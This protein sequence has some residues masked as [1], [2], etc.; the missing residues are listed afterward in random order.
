L[1][2]DATGKPIEDCQ[3]LLG[4]IGS[5]PLLLGQAAAYIKQT[6]MEVAEY[7][8]NFEQN[9]SLEA[10]FGMTLKRLS[11]LA[12]E[13]LFLCSRLNAALIPL[14]YLKAWL[15]L[16]S[17]SEDLTAI[18]EELEAYGLLRY[19]PKEEVFS[20]HLEFQRTLQSLASSNTATQA[21]SLLTI[22]AKDFESKNTHNWSK[23]MHMATIW[24]SHA[25]FLIES[26]HQ[27]L[28]DDL[29]KA[30]LLDTLGRWEYE[31]AQYGKALE[32]Y[33][34]ALKLRKEYLGWDHPD[35]AS[36][37]NNIGVW[38]HTQGNYDE[39][40]RMHSE[41]LQISRTALGENHHEVARCLTS[42]GNCYCS[43]KKHN[44]GLKMYEEVLKIERAALEKNPVAIA[45]NLN[46]IGLCHLSQK[47]YSE[48]LGKLIEALGIYRATLGENHP[49]VAQILNNIGN[50]YFDQRNSHE[51]LK[52]YDEAHLIQRATLG[53]NHPN[54]A[55]SLYNIGRCFFVQGNHNVAREM[56]SD[57]L[58]IRRTSLE[59]NHPSIANNFYCIGECYYFQGNYR[60][61]LKMYEEAHLIQ[62]A[63]E[64][65][66]E[67]ANILSKIRSCEKRL[68]QEPSTPQHNNRQCVV[69]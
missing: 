15:N 46:N 50:C 22:V 28:L 9:L 64:N 56:V 17:R 2:Q 7:L 55:M 3:K 48:A 63:R 41:A 53:E 20:L 34:A 67:V 29:E 37:L 61:A 57:A 35:I 23:S 33:S 18:I 26:S 69:S 65:H 1:L 30:S 36:S 45:A 68:D 54:I 5:Y 66:S 59:K 12:R 25:K 49:E 8:A 4:R 6:R 16:E 27:V 58:K 24:A 43:Q 10:A 19:N 21:A 62:L 31:K 42:I 60:E 51:A 11:P 52:M 40:L 32:C 44:K 38:Y 39:A 14:S 13:W 47:T